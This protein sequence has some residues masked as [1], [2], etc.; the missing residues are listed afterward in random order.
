MTGEG[1]Q[2]KGVDGRKELL[3]RLC[4]F[5]RSLVYDIIINL[6]TVVPGCGGNVLKDVSWVNKILLDSRPIT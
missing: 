3:F 6:I 2:E 5:T 4:S 1:G